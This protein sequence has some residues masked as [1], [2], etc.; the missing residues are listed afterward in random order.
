MGMY[1]D[2]WVHSKWLPEGLKDLDRTWQTKS[3]ECC[4]YSYQIR[5]NGTL[6]RNKTN[7]EINRLFHTG[8]IRF[9]DSINGVWYEFIAWIVKG[10][11]T[12]I[13]QI[14]PKPQDEDD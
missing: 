12:E 13:I 4:L 1:D 9:Y 8:E 6:F 7:M 5:E 11:V 14:E 3:L 2:I 10:T